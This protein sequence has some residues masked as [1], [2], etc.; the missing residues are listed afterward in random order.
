M[1]QHKKILIGFDLKQ[2]TSIAMI[3]SESTTYQ[4]PQKLGTNHFFLGIE[5]ETSYS[6]ESFRNE[7]LDKKI[8]FKKRLFL[9]TFFIQK[10]F[11]E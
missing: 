3:N 8:G 9:K 10:S 5:N 6:L 11:V 1:S 7:K 4:Q 2:V